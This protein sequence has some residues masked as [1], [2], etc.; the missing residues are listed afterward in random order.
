M[1]REMENSKKQTVNNAGIEAPRASQSPFGGVLLKW[2]LIEFSDTFPLT[3]IVMGV[4]AHDPQGR[5]SNYRPIM[6]SNLIGFD[7]LNMQVHTLN[8]IYTLSGR[9]M[10]VKL[11]PVQYEFAIKKHS[12]AIS[13]IARSYRKIFH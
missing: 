2:R 8:S 7:L 9:G 6:T 3:Q 10:W 4:I 5:F 12:E 11:S 13:K 1:D